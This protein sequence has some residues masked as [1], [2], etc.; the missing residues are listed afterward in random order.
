MNAVALIFNQDSVASEILNVG[1]HR[2]SLLD[3]NRV[4][5]INVNLDRLSIDPNARHVIHVASTALAWFQILDG[6]ATLIHDG[7]HEPVNA[8][9]VVFLP[10]GFEGRIESQPGSTLLMAN[11]KD[12]RRFDSAFGEKPLTLRI[13][14]WTREPV[15]NSEHDARKRIYLVTPALFGTKAIKGEMIIYPPSTEAANHHHEGAAHFM[16]I[17]TGSGTVY[18]NEAPFRVRE[19]DVVYYP[20]GERHYLRSDAT[21]EMRFVEFF[22]PGK[23]KTVWT[24]GASVCTWNPTGSDIHGNKATREIQ[25]HSS[26]APTSDI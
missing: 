9:H 5:G 21:A 19:G 26:A 23:Y 24:E 11:V 8:S 6:S 18:T 25:A 12:A 13:V 16:Y 2:Q 7:R 17:L 4:A 22:V 1:T 3:D 20:D 14:D 10:P 15:L